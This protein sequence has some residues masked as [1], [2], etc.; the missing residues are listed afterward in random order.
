MF[1]IEVY[2][3]KNPY[4]QAIH[5]TAHSASASPAARVASLAAAP[6]VLKGGGPRPVNAASVSVSSFNKPKKAPL[7]QKALQFMRGRKR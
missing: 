2:F 5:G 6:N 4:V 1:L 3:I 7:M